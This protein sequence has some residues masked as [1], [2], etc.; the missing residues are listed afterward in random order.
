MTAMGSTIRTG[1]GRIT[2]C[3]D[4]VSTRVGRLIS[5]VTEGVWKAKVAYIT[6]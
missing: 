3:A 2:A 5:S 4:V 1:K 6:A